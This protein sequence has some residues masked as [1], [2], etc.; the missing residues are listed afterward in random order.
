MARHYR[1]LDFLPTFLRTWLK[2]LTSI[3]PYVLGEIGLG[4][5]E[6]MGKEVRRGMNQLVTLIDKAP[7]TSLHFH[8][9][10]FA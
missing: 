2:Y 1:A 5:D 10:S 9:P 3:L 6:T 4:G 7:P 8:S